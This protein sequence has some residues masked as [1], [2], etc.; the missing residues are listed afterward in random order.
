[1]TLGWNPH[2]EHFAA[3]S[4]SDAAAAAAH[5]THEPSTGGPSDKIDILLKIIILISKTHLKDSAVH[6]WIIYTHIHQPVHSNVLWKH[7]ESGNGQTLCLYRQIFMVR[8]VNTELALALHCGKDLKKTGMHIHVAPV[9]SCSMHDP[10]LEYRPKVI[11]HNK[12]TK[13]LGIFYLPSSNVSF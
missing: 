8:S 4:L 5:K 11:S 1:M 12:L 10:V 9:S 2:P 13:T 6:L 7:N 3:L